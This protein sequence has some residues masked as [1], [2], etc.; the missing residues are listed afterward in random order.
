[1]NFKILLWT[2]KGYYG[3]RE[4][5]CWGGGVGVGE[6]TWHIALSVFKNIPK[7]LFDRL[8]K[9]RVA[10]ARPFKMCGTKG[11]VG[12]GV[13]QESS[14]LGSPPYPGWYHWCLFT[15]VAT[16]FAGKCSLLSFL[17]P[18]LFIGLA[19]RRKIWMGSRVTTIL[20][21]SFASCPL[22]PPATLLCSPLNTSRRVRISK[23]RISKVTSKLVERVNV[24]PAEKFSMPVV[25]EGSQGSGWKFLGIKTSI[26]SFLKKAWQQ[27]VLGQ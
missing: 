12:G 20:L 11:W 13:V 18:A 25:T 17:D 26:S 24:L 1:M 2:W 9:S 10:V 4:G 14:S 3:I 21:I 15:G 5:G 7:A 22:L 6:G 16:P 8:R 23:V 19:N 27:H